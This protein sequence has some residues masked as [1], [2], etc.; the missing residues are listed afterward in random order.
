MPQWKQ[1]SGNW[2]VTQQVQAKGAGTW[3][4]VPGA[5]TIGTATG[6][7]AQASVAFTAPADTGYPATINQY[8]V[9]SSPGSIT[10][11]GS[12]SPIIVTGLTNGT[13]Y[14]FT[15][16][17]TNDTGTG[18]ASAASNAVTPILS[19]EIYN[20]GINTSGELGQNDLIARSSPVQVGAL[21]TWT[22]ITG[23]LAFNFAVKSDNTA[24][25][26]GQG[27]LGNLGQN[28]NLNY[29][30]PVQLGSL[31][32]WE[33]VSSGDYFSVAIKTD[34]TLWAWGRNNSGELGQN[35][36]TTTKSSPVQIGSD[37]D[38]YK[39]A[40]S[41]ASCLA[42]K[43]DGTLW[44][45][46]TNNQ[47]QLGVGNTISISSPTQVG[48][49]TEW[50]EVN[51]GK[52]G[53]GLAVKTDGTLWIWGSNSQGQ[54]G[55]G[56]TISC[57]SPVQVGALTTWLKPS[58]GA[59]FSGAIKTDGTLWTWGNNQN[60]ELGQN[61]STLTKISSPVQV[62]SDTNWSDLQASFYQFSALRTDGTL[63]TWGQ[64]IDGTLGHN[65]RNVDNSSPVQVGS[66]T[67]WVQIPSGSHTMRIALKGT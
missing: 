58:G 47:G 67:T 48:T 43:T 66:L 5:P 24:W 45:W 44:T 49:L 59:Y 33:K 39:I 11:S 42:I 20:W 41:N 27:A 18:P 31:T 53:M 16:T 54:L 1:F 7:N 65:T 52:L 46:G 35:L 38:W 14:T 6:G 37:T 13:E 55:L 29:S 2:T 56:N 34:G 50:A 25:G 26:W 10:A 4:A 22:S 9:T 30:S 36:V 15:V 8:T 60:G 62:G 63:W 57:S 61:L 51:V 40:T 17:A 32:N 23:G 12:A 28:N 19:G 3:P 64:D 21:T